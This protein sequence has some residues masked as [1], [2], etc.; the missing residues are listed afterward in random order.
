VENLDS[1]HQSCKLYTIGHSNHELADFLSILKQYKIET[2]VDI[3]TLPGSKRYPQF[4][5]ENLAPALK[6]EHIQYIYLK[7]LGGLR[8]TH[9]DSK[10]IAWHNASF[11]GYADY[12]ETSEFETAIQELE[13][14]ASASV[15]GIMCAEV[16]WWR[17]H[18]SMVADYLKAKNWDVI[19]ILSATKTEPHHYTQPAIIKGNIV[20]YHE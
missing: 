11:R 14:I 3:R 13:K 16:L 5:Q 1:N 19:H 15:T 2:L 7:S 10:N 8:P 18:R 12:M 17:C 20:K 6:N 4:D 9:K